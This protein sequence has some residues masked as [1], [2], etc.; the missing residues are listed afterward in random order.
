VHS[1]RGDHPLPVDPHAGV[2]A[3]GYDMIKVYSTRGSAPAR[4]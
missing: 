3:P 2:A 4:V 1:L